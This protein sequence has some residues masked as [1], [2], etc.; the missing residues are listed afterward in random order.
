M[1]TLN[2]SRRLRQEQKIVKASLK[3][4]GLANKAATNYH[5]HMNV[6]LIITFSNQKNNVIASKK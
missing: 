3:L 4:N 2:A 5:Q 6:I 1:N